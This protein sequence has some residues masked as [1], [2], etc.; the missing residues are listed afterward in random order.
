MTGALVAVVILACVE[1]GFALLQ[2]SS[3]AA[4]VVRGCLLVLAVGADQLFRG[5]EGYGRSA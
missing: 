2:V 4:Y 5:L 3:Y 1:N